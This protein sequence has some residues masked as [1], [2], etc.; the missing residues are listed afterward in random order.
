MS[1]REQVFTSFV[2]IHNW[3]E[4]NSKRQFLI[5]LLLAWPDRIYMGKEDTGSS[6]ND[7][8]ITSFGFGFDFGVF[9]FLY[10]WWKKVAW[11]NTDCI[12]PRGHKCTLKKISETWYG[13]KAF[14]RR[15]FFAIVPLR[16]F[17]Y[18]M[19]NARMTAS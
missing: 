12:H 15:D 13:T 2:K 14:S 8:R 10:I 7:H 6:G 18:I 4:L 9:V 1:S 16:E 19:L 5:P 11:E 17:E 3:I